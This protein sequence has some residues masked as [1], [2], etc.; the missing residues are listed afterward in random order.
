M[1]KLNLAIFAALSVTF[2]AIPPMMAHNTGIPHTESSVKKTARTVEGSRV[3]KR[4]AK[5]LAPKVAKTH[6]MTPGMK[7]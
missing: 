3:K 1:T 6:K 4:I 7:M 2:S 5:K